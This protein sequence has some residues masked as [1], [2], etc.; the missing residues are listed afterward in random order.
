GV[1]GTTL[2]VRGTF[3]QA[4][5]SHEGLVD[6]HATNVGVMAHGVE[7]P[8]ELDVNNFGLGLL[9]VVIGVVLMAAFYFAR[10]RLR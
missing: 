7:Q 1:I 2:Q 5:T 8:D 6:V 10:E 9:L 3:N 4:C